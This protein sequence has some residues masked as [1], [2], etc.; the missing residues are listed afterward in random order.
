MQ[1]ESNVRLGLRENIGQFS[2]LVLINAFVG[3]M[4]GLE[5]TILP[6]LAEKE[7]GLAS[8]TAI[9][10]F[11]ISFGLTKAVTN[12][13]AGVLSDRV[14]RKTLLVFGWIA[15]LPVPFLLIIAPS[16]S[17]VVAANILLGVNQG[18][19]WSIA[20]VMKIDLV[21]PSKRGL[22][23]GLNEFAGYIAVA[24]AALASGWIAAEFGLRPYPF[25]LGIGF[26]SLGLLLSLLFVMDTDKH[27]AAESRNS[28]PAI[29]K[30]IREI[31]ATVSW[32]SKT[33]FSCSQAGMINNLNDGMV[34][35]LLPIY[36]A[37]FGLTVSK[38]GQLAAIYPAVWG[39]LQL[40]TGPM[41][42]RFGRKWMIVTGMWV[43]AVGIILIA[44]WETNFAWIAGLVLLGIGTAQVYPTLIAAV[45]DVAHPTWRASAVGVYRFWR[46]AGYA[47]GAV[48]SGLIADLFGIIPSILSI[49]ALTGISGIIAA[50]YM[51]ETRVRKQEEFE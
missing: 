40:V 43:Q 4:V 47:V 12:L 19:C 33:L 26:A 25:Y 35:G 29:R 34:W 5:R 23:M 50:I 39:F 14:G 10:S 21:G 27:V 30:G 32:K 7:F 37:S 42:D 2:L 9:L 11:I 18:L 48:A 44:L 22:A 1:S 38:I 51:V 20:V 6:L 16:W 24:V 15:G 49:G 36:F 13:F 28:S 45:S 3:G 41:S 31:F 46:D 17:W 8:K